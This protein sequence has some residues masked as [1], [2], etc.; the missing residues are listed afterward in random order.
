MRTERLF[1]GNETSVKGIG[2][3][4]LLLNSEDGGWRDKHF[5]TNVMK[6]R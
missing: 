2:L 1:L 5:A 4:G 3:Q 6:I